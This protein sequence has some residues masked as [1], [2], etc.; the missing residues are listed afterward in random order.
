MVT[1]SKLTITDT[2]VHTHS[3]LVRQRGE[4]GHIGPQASEI[5]KSSVLWNALSLTLSLLFSVWI[6]DLIGTQSLALSN[7]NVSPN[8]D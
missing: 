7:Q 8:Q 4:D 1:G 5:Q 6:S 2:H 3:E